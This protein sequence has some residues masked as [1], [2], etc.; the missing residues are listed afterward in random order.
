M[1]FWISEMNISQDYAGLVETPDW[2]F[3]FFS[4]AAISAVYFETV[5]ARDLQ[6][7]TKYSKCVTS[8]KYCMNL[9]CRNDTGATIDLEYAVF[10]CGLVYIIEQRIVAITIIAISCIHLQYNHILI[11]WQQQWHIIFGLDEYR[12]TIIDIDNSN[13]NFGRCFRWETRF[14][15][16]SYL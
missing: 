15:Q 10:I 9:P 5:I 4:K 7:K 13:L 8:I 2:L 12:S 1:H 11:C 16:I 14:T 3:F 6:L